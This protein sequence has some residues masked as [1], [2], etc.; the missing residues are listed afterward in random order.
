[1]QATA[2]EAN[3][4]GWCDKELGKAKQSRTVKSEAV[5]TLNSQL[6]EAEAKRNK[7]TEEISV[8]TNDYELQAQ[9]IVDM[10]TNLGTKFED[11][12]T[13]LEKELSTNEQTRK[14]RQRLSRPSM[15]RLLSWR[16]PSL[17]LPSK[18]QS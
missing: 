10:L 15:Q 2:D 5:P 6:A 14:E 13:E 7:L 18:S 17:S 8:L 4:K 11:E 16:C 12:R 3:H 1:M 9:G